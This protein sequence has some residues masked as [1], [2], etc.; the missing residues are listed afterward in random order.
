MRDSVVLRGKKKK[1][2]GKKNMCIGNSVHSALVQ[3]FFFLEP[4]PGGL[5]TVCP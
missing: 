5:S 4:C 2:E 1:Y 3:V